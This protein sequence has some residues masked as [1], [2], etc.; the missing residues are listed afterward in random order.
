MIDHSTKRPDPNILADFIKEDR[1][2]IR[3][4]KSRIYTNIQVLISASFAITS[5]FIGKSM[6]TNKG[7]IILTD[8]VKTIVIFTN[9]AFLVIS[10]IIF[11]V[12]NKDLYFVRKC[13]KTREDKLKEINADYFGDGD[14]DTLSGYCKDFLD[15]FWQTEFK[16]DGLLFF[17]MCL[18]TLIYLGVIIT[19]III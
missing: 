14:D 12:Q 15:T 9:I 10:W 8:N 7:D 11:Y 1:T 16:N 6:D 2:E 17:P 3:M 5:F 18:L 13:L 4:I 19:V